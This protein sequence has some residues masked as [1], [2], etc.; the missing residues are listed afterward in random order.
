M[1][2]EAAA[3]F[4]QIFMFQRLASDQGGIVEVWYDNYFT[5][6]FIIVVVVIIVTNRIF[7]FLDFFMIKSDVLLLVLLLSLLL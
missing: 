5:F 3:M 1:Y 4:P 7:H 6:V 2:L